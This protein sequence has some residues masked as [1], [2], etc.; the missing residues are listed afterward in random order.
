M[1][2]DNRLITEF[3]GNKVFKAFW[4]NP[5]EEYFVNDENLPDITNSGSMGLSQLKYH[6][7]WDWLI[8]VIKKIEN[9]KDNINGRFAVYIGGNG[10]TIQSTKLHLSEKDRIKRYY[11]QTYADTKIEAVYQEVVK[12]IKWYNKNIRDNDG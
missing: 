9:I 10:C 2:N 1:E 3:M 12:F 5:S 6:F 8:P 11:S 7:S 4:S